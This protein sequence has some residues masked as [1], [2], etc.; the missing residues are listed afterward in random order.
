M[1]KFLI[2]IAFTFILLSCATQHSYIQRSSIAISDE[3]TNRV[4]LLKSDCGC[5]IYNAWM[6]GWFGKKT[7]VFL[8]DSIEFNNLLKKS[9]MGYNT[10][11]I[12]TKK[13]SQK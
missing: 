7:R 8:I 3:D 4:W 9:K 5:M 11:P 10:Q 12:P 13:L 2:L 1:K 6:Q